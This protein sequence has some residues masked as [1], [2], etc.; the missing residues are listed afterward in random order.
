MGAPDTVLKEILDL[1]REIEVIRKDF[2]R[3]KDVINGVVTIE[4]DVDLS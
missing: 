3:R 1:Q 2:E 4:D